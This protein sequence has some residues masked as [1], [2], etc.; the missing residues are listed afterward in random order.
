M[1]NDL[2]LVFK[3]LKKEK[4]KALIAYLA[5]G[6]PRFDQETKL[7]RTLIKSGV[8]ILELGIPFSDPIADGPTIQFASQMSLDAGTTLVKILAWVRKNKFADSIPLVFMSYLNT[9][10]AYGPDKFAK[11]AAQA[12]V[13]GIII[14]DLI[15]EESAEIEKAL[16]KKN[17]HLICLLAPTTP[18]NRQISIGK[19]TKGFLYAVSVAGVTG[20]RK[21]FTP[22]T[23]K[24][25]KSLRSISRHPICVGF[26]ISGV[27]QIRQL[28]S[29]VDGFIIGSALIDRIRF[30]NGVSAETS[31]RKFIEPIMKECSHGR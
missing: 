3:K 20:A 15:P 6:Y 4:K 30:A 25:L 13:S 29:S 2:D 21:K 11:D 8:S 23:I 1:T 12:G 14:P 18:R 31:I 5:A 16:S 28:K 24:W 9:I 10:L 17:I 19:K 27:D 22:P 26:G 7:I